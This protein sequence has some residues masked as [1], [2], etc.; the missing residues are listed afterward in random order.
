MNPQTNCDARPEMKPGDATPARSAYERPKVY[1]V[2]SLGDVRS[3]GNK[4]P[5]DISGNRTWW[6]Q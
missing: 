3:G 4:V 5:D 6:Y 1:R 2:G